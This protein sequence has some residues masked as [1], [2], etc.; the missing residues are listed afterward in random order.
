MSKELQSK[1][2]VVTGAARG[3]GRAICMELAGRGAN[4]VGVDLLADPLKST[5]S[6]L[7]DLGVKAVAKVVDVT[8]GPAMRQLGDEVVGEFGGIDIMVNNA[9]ITRDT[10]L[11]SMDDEQ[12]DLVIRVNLRGV[13]LGT[14]MAGKAMLR[15]RSGRIINIASV[16][17]VMGNRGQANYAASKAGVIGLTKSAA[18]ELG[19]RGITCNAIAPGFIATDMTGVLPD[20]VKEAV[21]PLIP[22]QRFGTA[23]EVAGVVAFLAGPGAS[24]ITGQ[25]IQVDGG[26]RM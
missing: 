12:W 21:K 26:L 8:D 16:S 25:V 22:L 2:A 3:I 19:K 15:A 20:Q 4:I 18:K 17:G 7:G 11:L 13:Y 14:Q 10:L 5:V 24:Y 1:T 23:E 9:G 6:E